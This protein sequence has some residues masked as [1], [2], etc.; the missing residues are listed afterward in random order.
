M[1]IVICDDYQKMSEKAA[2]I[3]A[4]KVS[5]KKCVLGLATG[6]TPEGMYS[7]LVEM[8]KA[9]KC[10]FSSVVTFNLDEYYP[11]SPEDPQ[12]YRYYMNTKLF[13]LINIDKS[14][15]NVPN[16]AAKDPDQE[17]IA[18]EQKIANAGGIDIQVVGIGPNGHI[19]FNEPGKELFANTHVTS[20]TPSTIDAN[21]RFFASVDDVPTKALTMGMKSILS[22]KSILLVVSGANK[23]AP[24]TKL[25]N[26]TISTDCPITFLN[27][28]NDV[29][30]V[31]DREAYYGA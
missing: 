20:L 16:G 22:A 10:D 15:T 2:E 11:I 18:Y 1:N 29:T 7:S 17:C 8:N 25:L 14:N 28:H 21:S 9:G 4:N 12:S 31:C 23:H 24:L 13:D 27:L 6:S 26:G 5:G 30:L 3:V 19:G